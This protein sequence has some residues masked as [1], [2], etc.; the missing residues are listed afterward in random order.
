RACSE[1]VRG[2][3]EL[4]S[5]HSSLEQLK[6][7]ISVCTRCDVED[8]VVRAN[9]PAGG[10][11]PKNPDRRP[12]SVHYQLTPEYLFVVFQGTRADSFIRNVVMRDEPFIHPQ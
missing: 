5:H 1:T 9:D 10:D 6:K 7:E 3:S 12:H 11:N 4:L 8:G 2:V